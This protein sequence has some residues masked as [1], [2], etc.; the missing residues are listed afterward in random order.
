MINIT[1]E[2]LEAEYR[3]LHKGKK[4]NGGSLLQYLPELKDLIVQNNYQTVLDYGCGKA[5]VHNQYKLT[6]SVT[7]YDPYYEPYSQKPYGLYD[8]VICTDV[9]EHV[10]EEDVESVLAELHLYTKQLLFLAI[11][12]K[13]AKKTFG[14][15][16]NVHITVKPKEWWE[17][18]IKKY[19]N[20]KI[21]RHYTD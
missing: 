18:K 21:I 20:I 11:S 19:S 10:L 17:D 7:L 2:Y 12:T 3:R 4:F 8:L 16:M 15:G 6:D 9:L 13:K 14:N 1:K 5:V